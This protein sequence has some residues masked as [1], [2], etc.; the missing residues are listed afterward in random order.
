MF[1]LVI[2]LQAQLKDWEYDINNEM[3]NFDERSSTRVLDPKYHLQWSFIFWTSIFEDDFD[4]W[5]PCYNYLETE[6]K[7]L[8]TYTP[9]CNNVVIYKAAKWKKAKYT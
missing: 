5:R 2:I 6:K 8:K 1:D 3:R 9:N 7:S 4:Y